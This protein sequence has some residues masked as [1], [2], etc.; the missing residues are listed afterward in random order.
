[1]SKSIVYSFIMHF[2]DWGGGSVNL[3]WLPDAFQAVFSLPFLSDTGGEKRMKKLV[4][5]DKVGEFAHQ[6][7]MVTSQAKQT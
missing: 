5:Q 6:N 2:I 1:M 7:V 3:G 4:G